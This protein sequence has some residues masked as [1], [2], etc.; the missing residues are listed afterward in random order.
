M[1]GLYSLLKIQVTPGKQNTLETSCVEVHFLPTATEAR[2]ESWKM[3]D[4]GF[5]IFSLVL[6]RNFPCL[7]TMSPMRPHPSLSPVMINWGAPH[8]T[9]QEADNQ[10]TQDCMSHLTY[11]SL[12]SGL[13]SGMEST[14]VLFT[15]R[16]LEKKCQNLSC[17]FFYASVAL[18]LLFF[19][20]YFSLSLVL[21]AS[22]HVRRGC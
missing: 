21:T 9:K 5:Q 13:K 14:E 3:T 15:L 19:S 10:I 17:S 11:R 4:G 18:T 8:P 7:F 2:G 22:L 20:A 16:E 12:F 6:D 1:S